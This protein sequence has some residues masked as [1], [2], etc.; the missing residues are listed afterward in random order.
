MTVADN[1]SD[2]LHVNFFFNTSQST[3]FNKTV[4]S[5][6]GVASLVVKTSAGVRFWNSTVDDN[7][8]VNVTSGSPLAVNVKMSPPNLTL[9]AFYSDSNSS[10]VI[11][12]SVNE[13]HKYEILYD[14][15]TNNILSINAS[16]PNLYPGGNK[17]VTIS[18]LNP[19]T[20]YNFML[21]L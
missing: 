21:C 10:V 5:S 17:S 11:N 14:F 1:D 13:S 6:N 2:I 4:L 20:L 9:V 8:S 3:L 18:G 7:Q 19:A 16:D 15:A 12:F